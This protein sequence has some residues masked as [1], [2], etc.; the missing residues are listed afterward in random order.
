M[1]LENQLSIFSSEKGVIGSDT[2]VHEELI[3][4]GV[5]GVGWGFIDK[6]G[7]IIINPKFMSAE[8][9]NEG[10]SMVQ[11]TTNLN[12]K[13]GFIDK[14]GKEVIEIKFNKCGSFSNGLASVS[15][16]NKYGFIDSDGKIVID[17]KFD[18]AVDFHDELGSVKIG[19]LWGTIDKTGKVIIA[20]QFTLPYSFEKDDIASIVVG[21]KK[22]YINKKGDFIWNPS[23]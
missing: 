7:K 10:L 8:R 22:G 15:L 12:T 2:E 1:K 17:Y 5:I 20:P 6:N 19:K 9:F 23:K 16:T 21:D 3:H 18:D 4:V 11:K 13:C 14:T